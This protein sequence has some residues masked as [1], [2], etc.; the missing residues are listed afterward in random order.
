MK[1]PS[2]NTHRFA[3]IAFSLLS[4]VS[5]YLSL[6]RADSV[7]ST[8]TILTLLAAVGAWI[9]YAVNFLR[10]RQ[11][12]NDF[13]KDPAVKFKSVPEGQAR[14]IDSGRLPNRFN[15]RIDLKEYEVCHFYVPV[16][17][18]L[19]SHQPDEPVIDPTR[20][21]IRF[22]GGKFYYIVRPQEILLPAVPDQTIPG[23]LVITSQ[24]I[25]FLA[26]E[27]GFEVPLQGLK[28]LDCSAH[29]VDFHV[30]SRRYTLQTE[31]ADYAEKV[32]LLLIHP[33]NQT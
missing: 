6:G 14:L 4:L 16:L 18:V 5:S 12:R 33:S 23:E 15:P 22:S 3:A 29:L 31:A 26:E 28:L 9:A 1:K 2:L 24:R 21:S 32:L 17:R 8:L 7:W 30:R 11:D 19:F 20:L 10:E 13:G 25:I 27:N